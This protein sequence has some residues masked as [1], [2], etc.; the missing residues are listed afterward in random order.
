M[1][2]TYELEAETGRL[3]VKTKTKGD[4]PMGGMTLRR[5]YDPAPLP[6]D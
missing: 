6:G 3:L 4:G 2:E 1:S 5:V